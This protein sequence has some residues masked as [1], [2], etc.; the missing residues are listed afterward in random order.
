METSYM[1]LGIAAQDNVLSA[2]ETSK[3]FMLESFKAWTTTTKKMLPD[4]SSMPGMGTLGDLVPSPMSTVTMT[5]D[6]AEKVLASQRSFM[7]ELVDTMMPEP[8]AA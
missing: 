4:L 6:F 1:D 2:M 3:A 7:E 5:Y 8:A